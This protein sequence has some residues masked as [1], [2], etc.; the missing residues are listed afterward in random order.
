[1]PFI[2]PP[3][4]ALAVMSIITLIMGNVWLQQRQL[5]TV[6]TIKQPP[7]AQPVKKDITMHWM[8]N[9]VLLCQEPPTAFIS[10]D[11]NVLLVKAHLLTTLIYISPQHLI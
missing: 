2:T 8:Q 5:P 4:L 11:S 10:A 1:M 3:K 7:L 9:P 6:I